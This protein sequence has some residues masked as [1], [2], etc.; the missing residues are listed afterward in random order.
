MQ[1]VVARRREM[2]A[3]NRGVAKPAVGL[4]R[5]CGGW[6]TLS[7]SVAIYAAVSIAMHQ[8]LIWALINGFRPVW[9]LSTLVGLLILGLLAGPLAEI[10]GQRFTQRFA[11]PVAAVAGLLFVIFWLPNAHSRWSVSPL[12]VVALLLGLG[13][14]PVA[15]D[16]IGRVAAVPCE[17]GIDLRFHWLED[18]VCAQSTLWSSAQ[19]R[20]V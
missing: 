4:L 15:A 10:T 8:P 5:E 18:V 14:N 20:P 7:L 19:V 12:W 6:A 11:Q 9:P 17:L 2:F 3:E 1:I 16:L 13:L